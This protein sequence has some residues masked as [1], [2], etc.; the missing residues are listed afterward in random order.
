[1][2]SVNIEAQI[3]AEDLELDKRIEQHSQTTAFIS[4]KDH[5][6]NFE[7]DPKCRLINPAKSQIGKISKQIVEK[8]NKEVRAADNLQQWQSTKQ[9]LEWFNNLQKDRKKF[10]Q[11][12]IVE[13]YPSISEELLDKSIEYA[14]KFTKIT[15]K[16]IEII[17]HARKAFLFHKSSLT[18]KKPIPWQKKTNSD[19]DVT[20]GAPDGA[21]ICELCGLYIL[22]ELRKEFKTFDI[23]LYRD[24]GLAV[25]SRIPTQDLR[26]L[27]PRIK[28]FF[29]EKFGLRATVEHSKNVVNFLDVT[30]NLETGKHKPYRKPN[31]EPKYINTKSNHPHTVIKQIP[32]GVNK[33]L[34]EL[35]STENEFNEAKADYERAL[36]ES[37][38][39]HELK[40]IPKERNQRQ[41]KKKKR[42]IFWYNPP[43][44][45]TVTTC[46]GKKFLSL[47]DKH[48]PKGSELRG[49]FNRNTM[50][51]SYSCTGNIKTLI[52]AHNR[53]LLN[54]TGE[55]EETTKK[56]NCQR[57]RKHLCPLKGECQ[58]FD[59]IYQ[60]TTDENPPMKYIG[61][62]QDFK[63]RYS[64]HKQSFKR[65]GKKNA[66]T[67]SRH[68]WEKGLGK[69]PKIKWKILAKVPKYKLGT[70]SC[71]LCLTEKLLILK[72]AGNPC[73]LNK[74][75]ELAQKC[76]HKAKMRLSAL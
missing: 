55:P 47:V 76:R 66:T 9:V 70:K 6:P 24:D 3:I 21:E 30:L 17:K 18:Q 22:S 35:S 11:L 43:Y 48:F 63:K 25:S 39:K 51:V 45:S 53:K 62:T 69:E 41:N 13:Y 57:N 14:R 33:R 65:E 29:Q 38:H 67:L 15:D 50:K 5:K 60:A 19:F 72:N 1:M 59:V 10:I 46:I 12:D 16:D 7:N 74:R 26:N 8:V 52:Q 73:Y 61:S 27:E 40:F 42:K 54:K 56:C 49:L 75:S 4:A 58:Q 36:R 64:G 20:M 32:R 44:N 37:G 23:G 71:N 2:N 28:T 34:S 31:D 68:I